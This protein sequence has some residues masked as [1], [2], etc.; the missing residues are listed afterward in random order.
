MFRFRKKR[1]KEDEP[2]KTSTSGRIRRGRSMLETVRTGLNSQWF[3]S[4]KFSILKELEGTERKRGVLDDTSKERAIA[5]ILGSLEGA[6]ELFSNENDREGLNSSAELFLTAYTKIGDSKLLDRYAEVC[7]KA[8][9]TEEEISGRLVETAD[10]AN[11]IDIAVTLYSKAGATEKLVGAGNRALSLYLEASEMDMNSRSKL[12]NY[13]VEAYKTAN[14]KDALI[15]A[16]D[17]ALKSQIDGRRLSREKDWVLDAQKAYQ[18]AGDKA[19]LAKLADQYVNLYLK[20]GLETWLDKAVV[21]Y[22]EAEV[23]FSARLSKLAD[24]VEE[25][26]RSGM[27]DTMRRKAGQ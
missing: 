13:V 23:D 4:Q 20:E 26:G 24:K 16:G 14:D 9:M 18:A 6:A 7:T 17:K 5:S 15:Q 12:F 11:Q 21:A 27:A 8:G 1:R 2:E 10:G 22:E 25:R 19:K 3:R